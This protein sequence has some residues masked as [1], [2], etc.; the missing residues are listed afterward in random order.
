MKTDS[1]TKRSEN[2]VS[3]KGIQRKKSLVRHKANSSHTK[4]VSSHVCASPII[5]S[6]KDELS[7]F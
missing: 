6:K 1:D 5:N 7:T 3:F 2:V 4:S